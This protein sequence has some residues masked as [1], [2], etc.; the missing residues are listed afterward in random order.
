MLF[1]HLFQHQEI[2]HAVSTRSG[3]VSSGHYKSLNLSF[4]VGDTQDTIVKNYQVLSHALG[5][6]LSSLVTC[7]QVHQDAIALVD[8]SYF[9]KDCFLPHHAIPSTDALVTD[10]PGITLMTT[11]ADCVPIFFYDSGTRTIAI[12]HAGWK[13]TSAHIARKTVEV[14]VNEYHC[15][16]HHMLTAIGPSIGPCCYQISSEMADEAINKFPG[17]QKCIRETTPGALYFNL[18][19]ANK[20]ELKGAGIK[21]THIYCSR[22]CTA[23]N[24]NLF[25]SYRKEK[26]V[27]GRFGALIGIPG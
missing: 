6:D 15:Q 9:K 8:K 14:L 21:D 22:L 11:H 4:H 27:T 1:P 24:V 10:V 13:G 17:A 20:E 5:F 23:C 25:F 7:A 19:Q 3:G 26:K 2:M 16:P 18:R 12:A